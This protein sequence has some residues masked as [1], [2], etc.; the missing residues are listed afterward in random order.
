MG[1]GRG[2]E[3]RVASLPAP[4]GPSRVS[5]AAAA[6]SRIGL[7]SARG[8]LKAARRPARLS[9]APAA[10]ARAGATTELTR[11][12]IPSVGAAVAAAGWCSAAR[13]RREVAGRGRMGA[14]QLG[15]SSGLG[16]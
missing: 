8:G 3:G 15:G 1:S 2:L 6:G 12:R 10:R 4:P 16:C 7:S 9:R 5:A 14:P 11:A 13:S